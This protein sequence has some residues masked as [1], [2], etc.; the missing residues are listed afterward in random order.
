MATDWDDAYAN[1]AH[2]PGGAEYPAR[3][4]AAAASFRGDLGAERLLEG[5]AYGRHPRERFDLVLPE[6]RTRGL[7][8][9]VHG[10]YWLRFDRGDWT[11]LAAG[12]LARGWAVA[13]PG[14]PLAPEVGIAGITRAVTAA[15]AAA[16]IEV[17][18]PLVLGGHSAGGHLVTRLV[19]AGCGLPGGVAARVA[20]VVPIS[21]LFDLRPLLRTSMAGELRLDA[22]TAAAESPAL[23]EPRADVRLHAWVGGAERPEFLRQSALIANVWSGLGAETR[24]TV[25]P[26]RHHFDVIADLEDPGSALVE[27]LVG[28]AG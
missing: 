3:W 27:A 8:V 25:V 19:S 9:F 21:G 14:Y 4:R 17:G 18:G 16:A 26:E 12:P 24:L 5:I 2:I 28:E 15:V 11:H 10:G 22:A 7:V 13:L 1:A 23:G 6:G 20:R